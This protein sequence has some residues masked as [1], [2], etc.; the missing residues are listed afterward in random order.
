MN[1]FFSM[2]FLSSFA[3]AVLAVT[4]LTQVAKQYI[5]LNPKW[6]SL[7]FSFAIVFSVG[8][9]SGMTAEKLVLAVFN[10]L[11]VVGNSTGAYKHII[12]PIENKIR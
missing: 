11:L 9:V 4:L 12:E 5:N 1:I 8:I 10:S 7:I 3:G 2:E 6:I